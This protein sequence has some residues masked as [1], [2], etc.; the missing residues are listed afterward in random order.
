[1]DAYG[2]SCDWYEGNTYYCG[3]FDHADFTA[4]EHCCACG[5]GYYLGVIEPEWEFDLDYE[6]ADA[7]I[8]DLATAYDQYNQNM[9]VLFT[10]WAEAK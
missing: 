6:Q 4:S 5:G 8:A 10:E 1:M 9:A 2:D 3:A 7:Y